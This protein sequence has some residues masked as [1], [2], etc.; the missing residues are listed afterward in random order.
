M[1]F[2]ALVIDLTQGTIISD[3]VFYD[4]MHGNAKIIW[5]T[6]HYFK[7]LIIFESQSFLEIWIGSER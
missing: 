5:F 1:D 4:K 7:N 3:S 2:P 6:A